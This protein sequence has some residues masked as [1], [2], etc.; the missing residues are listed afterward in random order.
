M[1]NYSNII[2]KKH[3]EE[4]NKLLGLC[5]AKSEGMM[6]DSQREKDTTREINKSIFDPNEVNFNK[7]ERNEKWIR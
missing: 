6:P 4:L 2:F 7:N 1:E 3:F 5:M